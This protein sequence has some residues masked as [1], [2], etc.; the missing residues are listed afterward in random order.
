MKKENQENK[1]Q[2]TNFALFNERERTAKERKKD[3]E[4]QDCEN[5]TVESRTSRV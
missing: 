2:G 4:R 1:V 3:F 5:F